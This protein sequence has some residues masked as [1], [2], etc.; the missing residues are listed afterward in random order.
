M[1]VVAYAKYDAWGKFKGIPKQF[2]IRKYCE[3][4]YHF[5]NGGKSA[6]SDEKEGDNADI[7]YD[8]SSESVI[9]ED[10]CP[11][12]EDDDMGG[13]MTGGMGLKPS[14]MAAVNAHANQQKEETDIITPE[15]Y[16]RYSAMDNNVAGLEEALKNDECNINGADE[17]GQTALHFAADKGSVDC[18]KLLIEAGANI[19]AIDCDGIGILQ[20]ALCADLDFKVVRILLEAG[21][22]PDAC[23]T[24]G[25]SP[26]MWVE[27]QFFH[28]EEEGV[29]NM[30]ELF[31]SF[32]QR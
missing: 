19:N 28:M 8:E 5:A 24:D 22:D 9:D 3:V 25:D 1:N 7:V 17:Q 27:E 10:G 26:R 13:I 2:A 29:E 14:T 31:A 6:Y 23:D 16:L 15:M 4:V 20:T 11:I 12:N 32:P 21:A 30:N 18:I